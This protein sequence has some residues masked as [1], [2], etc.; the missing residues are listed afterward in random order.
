MTNAKQLILLEKRYPLIVNL[1]KNNNYMNLDMIRPRNETE[2]LILSLTKNYETL[3]KQTHTKP[4][5]T[6]E[7]IL[8]KSG[9]T[10]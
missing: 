2:D 4:D 10:F 9:K 6:I 8:K 7:I 3:I 5:E 1:I